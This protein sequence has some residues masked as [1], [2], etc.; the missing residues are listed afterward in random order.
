LFALAGTLLTQSA[1]T[2]HVPA[3]TMLDVTLALLAAM[4]LARALCPGVHG[5]GSS[6]LEARER[7]IERYSE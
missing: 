2:L 1:V 6:P 4:A 5:V 7:T 3:A